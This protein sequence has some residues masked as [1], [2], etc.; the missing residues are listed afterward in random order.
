MR[1]SR[2]PVPWNLL[3]LNFSE[4]SKECLKKNSGNDAGDDYNDVIDKNMV[5]RW[6]VKYLELLG[7]GDQADCPIHKPI[8]NFIR[9]SSSKLRRLKLKYIFQL[10]ILF[11]LWE[12]HFP[13]L[14]EVTIFSAHSTRLLGRQ[15]EI[16]TKLL[17]AAP[18]LKKIKYAGLKAIELIPEDKYGLLD[19]VEMQCPDTVED[20]DLLWKI[21]HLK[22]ALT[23]LRLCPPKNSNSLPKF[24]KLLAQ[25]LQSCH[26]S[27]ESFD[28]DSGYAMD[29]LSLLPLPN[30]T[31]LYLENQ[32]ASSLAGFWKTIT[33]IDYSSMMPRLEEIEIV[34]T[35]ED[36]R[37]Q[38]RI[39]WPEV[40]HSSPDLIQV[41]PTV[42]KLTLDLEV[43]HINLSLLKL[44]F[45]NVTILKFHLNF[46]DWD[47]APL[48]EVWELYP[49]LE[50]LKMKGEFNKLNCSYDSQFCGIFEEE[51]EWLR[52]R[53]EEYLKA[54]HIVP[55]RPSVL[56]MPSKS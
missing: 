12:P 56:T 47:L 16:F 41:C 2:R 30:L 22:P 54:V 23:I 52:T 27:L 35:F 29:Q 5:D 11:H 44:V 42:R 40:S 55:I 34:V 9:H 10:E 8:L 1:Q 33:S 51:A 37:P 7:R 4:F 46:C 28:A 53:D 45:P 36:D 38:G 3:E 21:A 39:Q 6:K 17:D 43:D 15:K 13:V 19:A 48:T 14:E 50:E 18:K 25:I 20:D 24:H 26:H 32:S 31:R 49:N